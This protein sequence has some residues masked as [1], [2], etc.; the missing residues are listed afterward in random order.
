MKSSIFIGLAACWL[1]STAVAVTE[2]AVIPQPQN[3][4][5]R[6]GAF[7]L[8]PD[9]VIATD[10]VSKDT[11]KFLAE[12]LRPATGY[13]VKTTVRKGPDQTFSGSVII[14]TTK[15]PAPISARKVTNWRSRPAASPSVH[16][17]R[18]ACFT[19]CKPCCNCCRRRFSPTK[20]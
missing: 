13:K 18:R 7:K 15:T 20:L 3:I 4:E 14:L 17:R 2:L 6:E 11:G 16:R 10:A 12:R 9:L 1:A 8:T 19:A 5:R